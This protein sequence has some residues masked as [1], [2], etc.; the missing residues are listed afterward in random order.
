M[1]SRQIAAREI[2]EPAILTAM[3]RVPR[4]EFVSPEYLDLAYSD[5]PLPI[6]FDQTISQPYVVA[7]MTLA[8]H[9]GH[10]D[11]VLEIGT[12]SGYQTAVL[13]EIAREVRSVEI[14]PGLARRG[15]RVLRFLGYTNI[16]LAVADGHEGWPGPGL[17]DRILL[18]A[19]P[20]RVPPALFERLADGGRLVAPVGPGTGQRVRRWT[21]RGEVLEVEDLDPVR[22]V[23]MTGG[24][25]PARPPLDRGNSD[26]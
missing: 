9:P 10:D 5:Q 7:Y 18:T 14:I 13:A 24:P 16:R 3:L 20:P 22:F 25:H 11:L 2:H 15:G 17:F 19:A 4:H 1:V 8:L 23:P 6:G 26:R 21:R 12:G